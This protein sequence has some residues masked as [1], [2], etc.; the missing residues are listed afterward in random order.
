MARMTASEKDREL[1]RRALNRGIIL[2]AAGARVLRRAALVLSRW[3][4]AKCGCDGWHIERDDDGNPWQ[5]V[6]FPDGK[7]IRYRI[8]DA[9]A[10][11]WRRA[12]KVAEMGGFSISRQLDPRGCPL[13]I[14]NPLSGSPDPW[15][16]VSVSG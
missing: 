5:V 15:G 8:P 1:V 4:E 14:W 13:Y 2:D 11:A 9:E 12:V 3:D 16:G 7:N 6:R 10:H